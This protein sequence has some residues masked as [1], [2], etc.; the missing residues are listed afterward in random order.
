VE[1]QQGG[2]SVKPLPRPLFGFGLWIVR[3][4]ESKSYT[5]STVNDLLL[6]L[7]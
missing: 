7:L 6:P 5:V 2:G 1:P 3:A 4:I